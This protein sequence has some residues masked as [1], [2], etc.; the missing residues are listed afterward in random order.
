V[1]GSL[2]AINFA[3]DGTWLALNSP[4]MFYRNDAWLHRLKLDMYEIGPDEASL[5]DHS[6]HGKDT[7][8]LK[9]WN[10]TISEQKATV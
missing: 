1:I 9:E 7:L 4:K 2:A 3:S 5:R 8:G 6:C 10:V